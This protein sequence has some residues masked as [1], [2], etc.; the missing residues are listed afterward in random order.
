MDDDDCL[1]FPAVLTD[2]H[3]RRRGVECRR[4]DMAHGPA[5]VAG[6]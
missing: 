3:S 6:V 4:P 1:L 5:R 2:G